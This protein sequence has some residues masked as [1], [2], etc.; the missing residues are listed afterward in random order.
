VVGGW[1]LG[2][3]V[4]DWGMVGEEG[5][6]CG[7]RE[8]ESRCSN[9]HRYP[10][11]PGEGGFGVGWRGV[12]SQRG[13]YPITSYGVTRRATSGG[14]GGGGGERTEGRTYGRMDRRTDEQMR[15]IPP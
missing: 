12:S 5:E 13:L 1:G 6:G 14:G 4:A 7:G 3:A 9:G 10:D 2:L 11:A 8:K 15:R